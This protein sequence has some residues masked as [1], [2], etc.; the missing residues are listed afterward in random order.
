M[1]TINPVNAAPYTPPLAT[2]STLAPSSSVPERPQGQDA[3]ELSLAGR[4]AL[5]VND[6][7]LTS[8]QGQTLDSQL[9]TVNQTIQSGGSGISQLQ[10]QLSQ[11]IYGDTHNGAT[12]PTGLTVTPSEGRDFFQAGR[13]AVQENAGNL[14]SAQGSQFLSQISQIYQ[15]SQN[16]A[17]PAA[18]NQA[19][20]QLSAEI[21][22]TAHNF[23][24]NGN[25]S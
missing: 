15:Q 8:A 9:Q 6:G 23:T 25:P 2:A 17:S 22:D 18:T 12:I 11:Q 7:E 1:S 4:I 5:G 16:G 14:T 20:N 13:V 21:F 24:P 19:Q 3:V 10:S